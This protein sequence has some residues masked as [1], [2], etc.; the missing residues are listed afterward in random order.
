MRPRR[1]ILLVLLLCAGSIQAQIITVVEAQT[2]IP[3]KQVNIYTTK[4]PFI[5]AATG[6]R[7]KADISR[8]QGR[9]DIR[10]ELIGYKAASYTYRQLADAE[11][12]IALQRTPL[13][14]EQIVVSASRWQRRQEHIPMKVS[15]ITPL[16]QRFQQPR[17]TA[18]LLTFSGD[19]FVQKSQLGGGSPMLRGFAANR[20][21]IS[22]DGIRMNTSIFRSGNVQNIISL[23][24]FALEQTEVL[25]GP[26]SVLYG[27]DAVGGVLSFTTLQPLFSLVNAPS[28][29]GNAA[30]RTNSA[31]R[32]RTG[33]AD[34]RIGFARCAFVTSITRTEFDDQRM[35]TYGPDEYLRPAYAVRENGSDVI[36]I[37]EDPLIQAGTGYSQWNILQKI[38]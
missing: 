26:G 37:N 22:V 10:L 33:H 35:G 31:N 2:R 8:F 30:V 5:F 29:T 24:P 18:D 14:M 7:G 28:V 13:Q 34:V 25:F 36:K 23:D 6:S 20:I 9:S 15:L 1:T 3:L 21:L 19:V 16:V 27:S 12:A 17:T 4:R 38:A 32:E 11:G